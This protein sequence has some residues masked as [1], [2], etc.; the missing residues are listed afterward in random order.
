MKRPTKSDITAG[1]SL[2]EILGQ[3]YQGHFP[4]EEGP[5][6][7]VEAFR[8]ERYDERYGDKYPSD[9]LEEVVDSEGE[10]AE[11]I[12]PLLIANAECSPQP[13]WKFEVYFGWER[14]VSIHEGKWFKKAEEIVRRHWEDEREKEAA[15]VRMEAEQRAQSRE[16][17]DRARLRALAKKY[18]DEL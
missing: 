8:Q 13:E 1:I 17:Q 15:R 14:S 10:V 7:R 11:L 9:S 3:I 18:P 12:A 6:F 4:V 2:C 5:R 16:R